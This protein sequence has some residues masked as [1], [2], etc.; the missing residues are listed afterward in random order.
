M[1]TLSTSTPSLARHSV[2]RVV[3][4]S[5]STTEVGASSGGS[6]AGPT[7]SRAAAGRSVIVAGSFS[8]RLK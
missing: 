3:P 5:H 6:S 8:R 7:A 4:P 1:S 2:F